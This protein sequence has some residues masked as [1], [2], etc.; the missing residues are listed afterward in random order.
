MKVLVAAASKHGATMEIAQAIGRW[1][2]EA[3]IEADVYAADEVTTLDGCDAV[4]LGSAVYLGRWLEPARRFVEHHRDELVAR[5]VWLFSSGPIG[6][7]PKPIEEPADIA[8][9]REMTQALDHRIFAGRLDK[10]ELG[11]GEKAVVAAVRA[12]D[13][14]FRAWDEIA[15]WAAGIANALRPAGAAPRT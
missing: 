10:R 7:P 14:D 6:D 15:A 4:V 9:I 2:A 12:P 3:G 5:P 13:G 11:F 1:F 8:P